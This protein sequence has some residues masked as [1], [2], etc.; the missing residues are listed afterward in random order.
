ME[1]RSG[2]AASRRY[3]C[4]RTSHEVKESPYMC[5]E[6]NIAM[7]DEEGSTTSPS[8]ENRLSL[9]T[10]RENLYRWK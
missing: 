1:L 4:A 10:I 6:G 8:Y 5:E 3:E 7:V 9:L 2:F